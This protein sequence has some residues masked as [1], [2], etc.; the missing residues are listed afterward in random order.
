MKSIP[1]WQSNRLEGEEFIHQTIIAKKKILC[2]RTRIPTSS[3]SNSLHFGRFQK[4]QQ[5]L[6]NITI[7]FY[8]RFFQNTSN[9]FRTRMRKRS[10]Q[11]HLNLIYCIFPC[12]PL[13]ALSQSQ[14]IVC[15]KLEGPRGGMF[16]Q[17]ITAANAPRVC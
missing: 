11:K 5:S 7:T 16:K 6:P 9:P 15:D 4:Q 1:N 10:L 17:I 2:K 13:T 14:R 3:L 8:A 12:F